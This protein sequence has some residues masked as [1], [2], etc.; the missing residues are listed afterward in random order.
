MSSDTAT[1]SEDIRTT[2]Q[3]PWTERARYFNSGNAFALQLP[4]VPS[5]QFTAERDEVFAEDTPTSLIDMDLSDALDTPYP[6]TTPLVLSRYAR[7]R[8]D[9]SLRVRVQASAQFFC[10]LRGSGSTT[11]GSE[12]VTWSAG[13]V[14][15]LPGAPE[16]IHAASEDTVAWLVT[17]EPALAFQ[18]LAPLSVEDSSMQPVHY[19]AEALDAE[20]E[21]VYNHP[22]AETFPGYAVVLSHAN[23]EHWRNIHQT[24]TLALNSLPPDSSQRPHVHNSM[25]L[26]LCLA[27]E[28]CYSMIDGERKDWQ[29][30]AVMLTPPAAAHSHHNA[31]DGRMRCLIVQDGGL[32]YHARTIGFAYAD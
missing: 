27:G 17:D 23:L 1:K 5:V 3:H 30:H 11:I 25:A 12:S 29:Q 7:I 10:V 16:V 8:A 13:D 4:P 21:G 24:M 19:P 6:A 31:G 9:E 18:E 32:Y 28:D 22:D 15:A 14:L 2:N 20:L 26:T